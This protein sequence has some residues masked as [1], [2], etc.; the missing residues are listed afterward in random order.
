MA[1]SFEPRTCK[2]AQISLLLPLYTEVLQLRYGM[3]WTNGW[4]KQVNI[5]V[6]FFVYV[7]WLISFSDGLYLAK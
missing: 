5:F 7:I 2:A 1:S 3:V 4:K 6:C